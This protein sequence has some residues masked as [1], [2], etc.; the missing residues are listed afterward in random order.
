MF[1]RR[2]RHTNEIWVTPSEIIQAAN[3]TDPQRSEIAM[4]RSDRWVDLGNAAEIDNWLIRFEELQEVLGRLYAYMPDTSK[5]NDWLLTLT[6]SAFWQSLGDFI[7]KVN[8][9]RACIKNMLLNMRQLLQE[10]SP[11]PLLNTIYRDLTNYYLKK[12][13]MR[14]PSLEELR[15]IIKR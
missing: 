5:D 9:D 14:L 3:L 7:D 12:I 4:R 1:R 15:K 13:D 8:A 10:D 2:Q 6:Q 11:D